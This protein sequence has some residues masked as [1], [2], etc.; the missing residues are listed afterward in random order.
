MTAQQIVGL[1]LRFFAILIVI[2]SI[3]YLVGVPQAMGHSDLANKVFIAYLFGFAGLGFAM[4]LWFF[5]MFA[6]SKILPPT[7]SENVLNVNA[8]DAAR[9]GCSLIGLWFIAS[10]LPN[11]VWF[12]FRGILFATTTQ[13]IISTLN[14]PE[15]L[16]A[17][18]Y[19]T[20]L[21]FA[22]VLIFKSHL[23]AAVAMRKIDSLKRDDPK[24]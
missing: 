13:S 23:F 4:L 20:E 21:V 3:K 12:L 6:A 8:V 2:Y 14:Q 5:P 9:V 22:F 19:L 17:C 18:F 7:R 15:I 1:G 16:E 11:L 24:A 10:A